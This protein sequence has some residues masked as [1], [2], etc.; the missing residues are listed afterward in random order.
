MRNGKGR[1]DIHLSDELK[2]DS[3]TQGANTVVTFI[4]P[5][6]EVKKCQ[7]NQISFLHSSIE[8]GK[9]T[10]HNRQDMSSQHE[11]QLEVTG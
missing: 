4:L 1:A 6:K 10:Q 3:E 8:T 5:K 11:T 2:W 9:I 7:G